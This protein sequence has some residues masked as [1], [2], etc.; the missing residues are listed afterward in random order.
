MRDEA[1]DTFLTTGKVEDYLTYRY[2]ENKG[3]AADTEVRGESVYGADHR[4]DRNGFADN[5]HG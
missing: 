2:R 4:T 5:A 1:W 3:H